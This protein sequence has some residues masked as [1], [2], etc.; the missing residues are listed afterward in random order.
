MQKER[1]GLIDSV[2]GAC[3]LGMVLYHALF[4]CVYLFGFFALPLGESIVLLVRDIGCCLFVLIAGISAHFGK[5]KVK[6]GLLLLACGLCITVVT[7]WIAPAETVYYGVL[8]FMGCAGLL[9]L[10]LEKCIGRI[11]AL[12]G[13]LVATGL[14]ALTYS[15]YNGTLGF[16]TVPLL[17]M[18]AVLYRNMAT[19]AFGF[20]PDGF[21]SGDYFPLFPWFFLYLAGFF[22]W[23]LLQKKETAMKICRFSVPV[24]QSM[25]KYSLWIYLA[26][27]PVLYAL[28][29]CIAAL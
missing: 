24:L 21:L 6:R 22:F 11:P 1:F 13:F 15:V 16:F 3:V 27:Q 17:Q 19:A 9:M 2:R 18:P 4:D 25:G 26:H 7:R 23:R 28:C 5:H 20:P 8:T 29:W 14:F 10:P 12:P